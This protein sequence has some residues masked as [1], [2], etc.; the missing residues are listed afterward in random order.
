M[1]RVAIAASSEISAEAGAQVAANGGNAV[2]AVIAATLV[3]MC[4]DIGIVSPAGG[5]L[6]SIWPRDGG[7]LVVDGCPEMPGR[8][9]PLD[10][11]GD[12]MWDVKFNY[13]GETLQ[14]IGFGS[15]ATPGA[16]AALDET[17]RRFGTLPWAE[18]VQPAIDHVEQ[19]FPLR[20]GAAEYLRY[21]HDSIYGWSQESHRLLHHGDGSP[22]RDGDA[23]SLPDLAISLREIASEGADTFYRGE[24]ARR[25][26]AGVQEAGGLLGESDLAEYRAVVCSP[27]T[28]P[29]RDWRVATC[30]PPSVGGPCLAA[31]LH[32]L[33]ACDARHFDEDAARWLVHTQ[34]AIL[35]F[36]ADAL[37]G[38]GE[39]V[40]DEVRRLLALAA[41]G[42]PSAFLKSPSTI[43]LSGIDD[44]GLACA[45][46]V[47]AGYGSGA[48]APGTGIWL[49]NSLGE[50]DLHPQG[51]EG[52]VPGTRLVSNMAPSVARCASGE[53]LA[54]GSPGASRITT[55]IAQCLWH[56]LGF[57][58]SLEDSV[59]H[60]RLHV[61]PFTDVRHVAYER[62]LPVPP[63]DGF[64]L[65]EFDRPHM[66]FGGVQAASW[67]PGEGV[68]AVADSRRSGAVAFGGT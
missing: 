16:F 8:G 64:E 50:A 29:F 33:A 10:R 65:R 45:V 17:W 67:C 63:V 34:N 19:G 36:R 40:T 53:V 23:L 30:P 48:I 20:G 39:E 43:H 18:L 28:L 51:L 66:Y 41:E 3:S 62:G 57:R 9:Q 47:S 14:G 42:D 38:A 4:T 26:A 13:K 61:E 44:T 7:P 52:I 35:N 11:F 56:H 37:D 5:A 2:D 55:A 58:K 22:L 12:A 27:I 24:L 49:N 15:V 1:P 60:P 54:I 6:V 46:T 21:T 59:E 25:I 32:L 31:M 68:S